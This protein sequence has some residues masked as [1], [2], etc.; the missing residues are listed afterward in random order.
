MTYFRRGNLYYHWRGSV[1][2]SCSGWEG[3]VPLCYGRQTKGVEEGFTWVGCTFWQ[4]PV[5]DLTQNYR[6]KPHGQ[7]VRVSLRHYCPSTPRLSTLWSS[8]TL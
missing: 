4:T 3:V 2:P 5:F 8:T 1:S 7:L 6:V